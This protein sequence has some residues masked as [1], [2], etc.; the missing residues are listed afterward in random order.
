MDL[1]QVL[2]LLRPLKL[3]S[4]S[5]KDKG[6]SSLARA[7]TLYNRPFTSTDTCFQDME[8]GSLLD[9]FLFPGCGQSLHVFPGCGQVNVLPVSCVGS[10]LT[11]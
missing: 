7:W 9:L 3:L 5:A 2:S 1:S 4:T 8:T 10:G 6:I 11:S